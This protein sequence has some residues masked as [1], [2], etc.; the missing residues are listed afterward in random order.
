MKLTQAEGTQESQRIGPS[1]QLAAL[2]A[3]CLPLRMAR[4]CFH[5]LILHC[6]QTLPWQANGK[7]ISQTAALRCGEFGSLCEA[8]RQRRPSPSF[9][10]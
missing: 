2:C 3:P 10:K 1:V 5:M 7:L 9:K 8:S 4:I 6:L